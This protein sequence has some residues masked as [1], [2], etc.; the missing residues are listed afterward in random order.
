MSGGDIVIS[1]SKFSGNRAL[2]SGGAVSLS[3]ATLH[4]TNNSYVFNRASE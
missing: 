2:V 3:G 1:D 4:S